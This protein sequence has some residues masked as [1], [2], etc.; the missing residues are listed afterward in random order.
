[1]CWNP[2]PATDLRTHTFVAIYSFGVRLGNCV[3]VRASTEA[4]HASAWGEMPTFVLLMR[5]YCR[6]LVWAFGKAS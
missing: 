6:A 4:I 5:H 3:P 2:P 1:V